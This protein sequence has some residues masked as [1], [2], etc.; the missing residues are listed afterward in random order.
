MN[1]VKFVYIH[2][3]VQEVIT[4]YSSMNNVTGASSYITPG[5]TLPAD[6]S[7]RKSI[8]FVDETDP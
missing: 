1:S 7:N 8:S 6:V 5:E 3:F 4:Y 2:K